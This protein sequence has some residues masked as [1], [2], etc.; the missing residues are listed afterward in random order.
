MG[1]V[2][3]QQLRPILEHHYGQEQHVFRRGHSTIS[4]LHILEAVIHTAN[5][6]DREVI[7]VQIDVAK[8]FDKIHRDAVKSFAKTII[9]PIAPEAAAFINGMYE[10]DEVVLSYGKE[11]RSI[12][13]ESGI[14]QGDPLSPAIFSALVGHVMAPLISRWKRQKWGA[15]LDPKSQDD[16]IT[17]LAY[18]DDVTIFAA[19][20]D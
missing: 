17:M 15:E 14:R 10:G 20:K 18:A 3:S 2:Y 8:A 19:S 4:L 1:E 5:V 16:T 13:M 9:E 12:R 6:V 11:T 7:I